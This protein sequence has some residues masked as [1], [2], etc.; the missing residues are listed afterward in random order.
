MILPCFECPAFDFKL[1]AHDEFPRLAPGRHLGPRFL[2]CVG[3]DPNA[4]ARLR[5]VFVV[6]VVKALRSMDKEKDPTELHA[7]WMDWKW[8][9][10]LEATV[11]QDAL[12]MTSA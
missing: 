10:C 1:V 12:W 4:N 8:T 5:W 11:S 3:I 6:V 2:G 7:W 9:C